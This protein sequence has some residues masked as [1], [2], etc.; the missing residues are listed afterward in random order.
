MVVVFH[1]MGIPRQTTMSQKDRTTSDRLRTCVGGSGGGSIG[2]SLS[3]ASLGSGRG[4]FSSGAAA[5][6]DMAAVGDEEV[7]DAPRAMGGGRRTW[8]LVKLPSISR[9]LTG[10]RHVSGVASRHQ[11]SPSPLLMLPCRADT[12]PDVDLKC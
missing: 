8:L 11:H 2:T 9:V 5:F 4:D 6:G 10:R 3:L 1:Q 12:T 7:H